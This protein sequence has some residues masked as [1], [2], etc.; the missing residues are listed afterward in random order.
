MICRKDETDE[1]DDEE[2]I[3][4]KGHHTKMQGSIPIDSGWAWCIVVGKFSLTFF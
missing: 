4:K 1:E 3:S 2:D